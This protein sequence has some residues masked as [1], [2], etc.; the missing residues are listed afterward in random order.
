MI[1]KIAYFF[2]VLFAFLNV[3]SADAQIT[4]L[5]M[6]GVWM[7]GAPK[8]GSA[9]P[10]H[11]QFFADGKFVYH[12]SEYDERKKLL[13]AGGTYSVDN[14]ILKLMITYRTELVG[15]ELVQGGAGFQ[16]EELVLE[17]GK[18]VRIIQKSKE[19]IEIQVESCKN[20]DGFICMKLQNNIY[21]RMSKNPNQ[22]VFNQ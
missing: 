15:G 3:E 20:K 1:K 2:F 8:T 12:V 11:Y 10:A 19:P 16:Q 14:G 13:T 17:G 6:V 7:V 18:S 4:K 21:Y 5:S 9:F 22:T